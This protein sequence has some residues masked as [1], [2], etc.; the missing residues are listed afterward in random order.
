MD[1]ADL[2]KRDTESSR[3]PK[4]D[5][6]ENAS[7]STQYQ[8]CFEETKRSK[9]AWIFLDSPRRKVFRLHDSVIKFGA[10]VDAREAQTLQ[11]IKKAT[12]IPVPNAISD[13]PN[14]IVMDY[15]EGYNLEDCWVRLS[16][17]EKRG[18][19]EQ[20]RDIILQLRSFKSSYIGAVDRG[21]AVDMRKS[22]YIGGPF[23]SE[24]EF[25]EFLFQ[26][27]VSSS[28]SLYS[29]AMRQAMRTNHNIVF[30]HGDLNLHNI[31]VKDGAIVALLDW[32]YA[33]WY[34]EHWDYVKFCVASCHEPAWHN[35]GTVI[36]PTAYP[37]ELII[38]QCYA[39][40]VF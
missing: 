14:T 38:D 36:F 26:N 2:E 23:D 37:D 16:S 31:L 20:T 19:A 15:I 22:T 32:E 10:G 13:R 28:P 40:F 39:L 24:S 9:P 29:T 17:E 27:M 34:P 8:L 6:N 21:P 18:I 4:D 1:Q 33:G 5:L 30:S 25:N 35:L 7:D 11:F 3:T 12:T